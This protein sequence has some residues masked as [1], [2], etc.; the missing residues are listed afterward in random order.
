M[1][2]NAAKRIYEIV[3][4]LIFSSKTSSINEQKTIQLTID[5][6]AYIHETNTSN[7]IVLIDDDEII[8][9]VWELAAEESGK[10]ID[11]YENPNDFLC[12]IHR[13]NKN[14]TIYIDSDL[15]SDL[16]GEVYAKHLYGKGFRDI[17][18]ASGYQAEKFGQ[19]AWIKSVIGKEPPF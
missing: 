14:T 3:N 12:D 19:M 10:T 18:I 9:M 15:K 16:P 7:H 4:N 6:N 2:K 13:Y 8:R 1:I 17:H 5:D 11:V